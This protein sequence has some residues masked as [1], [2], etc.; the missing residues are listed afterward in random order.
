[1]CYYRTGADLSASPDVDPLEDNGANPDANIVAY[2]HWTGLELRPITS[3]PP[4]GIGNGIPSP[5]IGVE[6]VKI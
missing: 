2:Y 6:R 3:I 1:M 5:L 4:W